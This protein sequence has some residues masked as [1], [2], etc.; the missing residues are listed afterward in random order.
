M[1]VDCSEMN[2]LVRVSDM[3]FVLQGGWNGRMKGW[4]ME[5]WEGWKVGGME[6]GRIIRSA[7]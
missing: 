3:C 4:R 7:Y 5:K 1:T 6:G 2:M